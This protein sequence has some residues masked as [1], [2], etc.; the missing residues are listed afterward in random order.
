MKALGWLMGVVGTVWIT[1]SPLPGQTATSQLHAAME[2]ALREEGLVGVVWVTVVPGETTATGAAGLNDA[3][4][5]EPLTADSRVQV[6]S[7]TKTLT[8]VGVLRLVTERRLTLDTPVAELLPD[9]AFD[10][11]WAASHPLLLHHLLDGTSGLDDARLWQVFTLRPRP[12]TPLRASLG[13]DPSLLRL[14]SRPGSRFSYSNTGFLLLGLVVE[15]VT[16]ERYETYL[17]AHLLRPLG[18][19]HSTFQF[20]SQVGEQADARLAMGHF[21]N[22]ATQAIVPSYL[23]PAG[24]FTTTVTDMALFARFLMGSGEIDGETFI[25][26]R[27]LRAMGRPSGTE[28]AATGLTAGY[29]LGLKRRDRYGVVGL[30]HDGSTVGYHAMLC[31]FPDEQKAFSVAMNADTETA[32]YGRFDSLLIQALG[33]APGQPATPVDVPVGLADWQGIYVLAPNRFETFAYLDLALGFARVQWDGARLHL[34]PLQ[35]VP[36]ELTPVGGLLFRS[37]DRTT[38]SHALLTSPDGKRV[39]T[40]GFNSYERVSLWRIGPL[41]ASLAAGVLGLAY[42]LVSGLV[43]A[44]RRWL[45]PVQPIFVPFLAVVALLLPVPLFLGQSFLQL[46][47]LTPASATL[48]LVTGALPLAMIVGLWRRSHRGMADWKARL[49]TVAMI[50]VLQWT[51]V[52]ATWGLVPLRLWA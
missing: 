2:Q 6:G 36:K 47:D 52:L 18:M 16:G 45:S 40:D 25:D 42:L 12:D 8:A 49:D 24:Q 13:R 17:D 41:W 21:E 35:S 44:A 33:V 37:H 29:G 10:N 27:L 32:D 11:P 20:V 23:R 38:A 31:L 34:K 14:R 48:A 46:G 22:G 15:A 51:I 9:L 28:A 7:V 5:R 19:T 50:A 30:C 3:R 39:I 26:A 4:R 1:A 43:R